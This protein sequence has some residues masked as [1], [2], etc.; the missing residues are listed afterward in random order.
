MRRTLSKTVAGVDFDAPFSLAAERAVAVLSRLDER[1]LRVDEGLQGGVRARLDYHDAHS[2]V[3]LSG[4]FLHF[5]DFVLFDHDMSTQV[6]S[7]DMERGRRVLQLRR[8]LGRLSKDKLLMPET[9]AKLSG[10]PESEFLPPALSSLDTDDVDDIDVSDLDAALGDLDS[11]LDKQ[12]GTRGP[13]MG[14]VL[15]EA[16]QLPAISGAVLLFDYWLLHEHR[17]TF[18]E[19]GPL[20]ASL[21][22]RSRGIVS[23]GLPGLCRGLWRMRGRWQAYDP[24]A[25]RYAVLAESIATSAAMS[26]ADCDRLV[27]AK[28]LMDRKLTTSKRDDSLRALVDLFIAHPLVNVE[29]AVR[30][31][32]ITPQAVELLIKRLGDAMPPELTGRSRYRAWG[33]I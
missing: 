11:I 19:I 21:F 10:L 4:G 20:L 8:R 7:F 5:S 13:S 18:T 23:F 2:L 1:L 15:E 9:L 22:L 6:P 3:G 25:K 12:K 33:I 26:M 24:P 14:A 17:S 29:L 28:Q 16:R 30:T 32:K 31:L 27:L